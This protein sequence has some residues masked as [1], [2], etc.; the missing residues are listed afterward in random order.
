MRGRPMSKFPTVPEA[1]RRNPQS[2][3]EL[4]FYIVKRDFEGSIAEAAEAFD[5]HK[6]RKKRKGFNIT[7][8]SLYNIIKDRALIRYYQLEAIANYLKIPVFVL[9]LFTRAV[10]DSK[11][12]N[13]DSLRSIRMFCE[14]LSGDGIADEITVAD[15][16]RW[17]NSFVNPKLL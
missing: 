5:Q 12:R 6:S 13:L 1:E 14:F 2:I 4:I 7:S 3:R 9:L 15:I 8:D 11:E 16:D 17:Q 10:S